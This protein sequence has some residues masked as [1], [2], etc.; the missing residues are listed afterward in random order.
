MV[1]GFDSL[2]HHTV[3]SCDNDD[4]DVCDIRSAGTHCRK[5]SMSRCIQESDRFSVDFDLVS[6]DMLRDSA[7]FSL[8][9]VRVAQ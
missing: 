6:A 2:R 9:Y 3:V 7:C 5:G 8:D 1:D 4:R